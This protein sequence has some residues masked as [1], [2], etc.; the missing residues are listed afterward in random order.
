[1]LDAGSSG[2]HT[3][4]FLQELEAAGEP[5]PTAVVYTHS[6]WDHVLG[7]AELGAIVIAQ[8][9]T[10]DGLLELAGR[11]WSDEGLDRRVA[12]GLSSQD[13]AAHV[14]AE[15]PSPRTVEIAPADVVFHEAVELDLGGVKVSARHVGGDHSDDSTVISV[16]PDEVL[17][18]GDCLCAS[19]RGVLTSDTTGR[20]RAAILG[21]TAEHFVEGHHE[22]ISSRSDIETLFEKMAVA[23]RAVRDGLA[24][25][26]PDE[27]TDYFADAFR[28]G[29]TGARPGA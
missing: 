24:L 21:F 1:M 11:D 25:E 6:H 28:A 22:A 5:R 26:A 4:G 13:Y 8:T 12:E 14:K 19:P 20:L 15:M 18:L 2:A 16:E 29:L 7:G 23:E 17:F 9:L 27:D 10:V 3:R